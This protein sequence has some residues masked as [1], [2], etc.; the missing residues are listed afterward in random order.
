M[1]SIMSSGSAPTSGASP[2]PSTNTGATSATPSQGTSGGSPNSFMQL[3]AQLLGGSGAP[4]QASADAS[5]QDLAE[6]G[7]DQLE[8]QGD[9]RDTDSDTTDDDDAGALALAAL[10]PGLSNLTPTASTANASTG[11]GSG[12][13]GGDSM[14]GMAALDALAKRADLDATQAALNTLTGDAKP[15]ATDP[16]AA[17]TADSA[18]TQTAASNPQ[19][20]LGTSPA[21]L[22]ALMTAHTA[23]GDVDV[24]PD[25]TLRAPVGT[26]AWKDE[27]GTQLTWM[28]LNG[29]E[30]ASLRL[31]P[32]HL[33]PVEVRISMNDGG[34]SVYFG[35]S[36][37]ET[38][39][40]LEQSLP[41]LRE[42]FASSGLVL[43]DAGVSRDAPRNAFK[44]SPQANALRGVS[45]ASSEASVTSITSTRAGLV[46]T[47]V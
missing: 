31:S 15:D 21:Q 23:S 17:T 35:A 28:A 20:A 3:V 8:L 19:N 39:N 29:R 34:T 5:S 30:A 14:E 33:G 9:D 45:D 13:A 25:A 16:L 11:S 37:P 36:N 7:A 10:L 32:E 18:A 2:L 4:S 24:A 46:D 27:L 26:H 1:A 43:A 41:R 6:L 22:H 40:A 47:Y 42:M 38:R 44:P 12:G